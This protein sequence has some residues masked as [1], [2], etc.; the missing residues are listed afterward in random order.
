VALALLRGRLR[1][2]GLEGGAHDPALVAA[3][4]AGMDSDEFV[5]FRQSLLARAAGYRRRQ[6]RARA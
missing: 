5:R 3:A 6:R 2:D 4:C 1:R